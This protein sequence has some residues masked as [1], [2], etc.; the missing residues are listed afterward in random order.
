MN[1]KKF[2]LIFKKDFL[3]IFRDKKS[4]L[5]SIFVTVGI[6]PMLIFAITGIEKIQQQ[7]GEEQVLT[8]GYEDKNKFVEFLENEIGDYTLK[9]F[10]KETYQEALENE[11]I[12]GH[13]QLQQ[14]SQA[15]GE[16]SEKQEI[17]D[18]QDSFNQYKYIYNS[19]I[20][21]SQQTAS[22]INN[23]FNQ[24]AELQSTKKLAN[25][26]L[27][28]SDIFNN[29]LQ[30]STIVEEK[31]E[32]SQSEIVLFLIPY[33]ILIGLVQGAMAYAIELTAG[34]KERNT[35]ATTL[36]LNIEHRLIALSK[37][38]IISLFSL[39]FLILNLSSIIFAFSIGLREL[40]ANIRI[41][42]LAILQIASITV[43]LAFLVASGL[44]LLGIYARNQKEGQI[45]ATPILI[46]TILIGF[47]STLFDANTS[48]FIFLIP[49]FGHVAGIKQVLLGVY[50]PENIL[51]LFTS[52]TILFAIVVY[53]TIK[54]FK[55]EN[56]LFR[57]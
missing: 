13:I 43:P 1:W 34:E 38:S 18:E 56:V 52:T 31:G 44:I 5:T 15:Q 35:L 28:Y 14:V 48:Q 22:E 29:T 45:Y 55:K 49:L 11:E 8:I 27:E 6:T 20:N 24:F 33:I 37:I 4:L 40:D 30:T 46:S 42:W 3:H 21:K 53:T 54:M 47:M 10:D 2:K 16:N 26:G 41:S 32:E 23:F 39:F 19:T 12:Y 57:V 7:E 9:K 51:L 25:K 36:L 50:Y 17:K